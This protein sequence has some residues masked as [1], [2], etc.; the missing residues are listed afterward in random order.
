MH[1]TCQSSLYGKRIIC[2]KTLLFNYL[3]INSLY[4]VYRENKRLLTEDQTRFKKTYAYWRPNSLYYQIVLKTYA[5]WRPN[6]LYY[7]IVLKTYAYWRPNSLYYQIVLKK[8]LRLLVTK[9]T[10]LS[11]S[12]QNLYSGHLDIYC[13]TQG[14]QAVLHHRVVQIL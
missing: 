10:I 2:I 6:S 8:N 5:Y 7:Q 14:C 9:L 11:N 13:L 1:V 4:S 12:F 3:W